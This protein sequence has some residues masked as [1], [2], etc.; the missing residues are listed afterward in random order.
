MLVFLTDDG[1]FR[2]PTSFRGKMVASVLTIIDIYWMLICVIQGHMR[3][4]CSVSYML[5]PPSVL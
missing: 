2:D 1:A 4:L 5:V 3:K